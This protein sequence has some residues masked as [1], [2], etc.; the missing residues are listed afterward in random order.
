MACLRQAP[1]LLICAL[2]LPGAR[3]DVP[4][5]NFEWEQE[6]VRELLRR[7]IQQAIRSTAPQ[8]SK[9]NA[10]GSSVRPIESVARPRLVA[11]YGVGRQ[12][13]AEV[14]IG[15]RTLIYVRGHPFPIGH[16]ADASAYRLRSMKG[17]CVQLE[18]AHEQETLC[19]PALLGEARP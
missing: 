15:V 10:T 17:R 13:M 12:L 16:G 18:R 2:L 9:V 8:A 1:L 19:L 6:T 7:D 11:L 5:E 14:Q 3:A 4:I